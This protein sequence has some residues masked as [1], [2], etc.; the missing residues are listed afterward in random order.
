MNKPSPE[1]SSRYALAKRWREAARPFI[2]EVFKFTCPGREH[3]FSRKSISEYDTDVFISI[4]EEL[5][6]DLAG[7]LA[8]YY[9][10]PETKWSNYLV[11]AEIPEEVVDQ[12]MDLV[13]SR[14]DKLADAFSA[15][16]YYDMQPQMWFE[17]AT[18]GTPAI[19]VQKAHLAQP[20]YFEV[21]PPHELLITPGYL[22]ILDRFRETNV[23]AAALSS[24]AKE[25]A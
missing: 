7:D 24:L 20:I 19:W 11:T 3:D 6:T 4:G 10:P 15:S 14:E 22:G 18:H 5:A 16:N 23:P 25:G 21:V 8:T 12:V 17:A 9:T 13:Q 1:F 2:E